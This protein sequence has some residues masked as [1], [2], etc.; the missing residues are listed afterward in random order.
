MAKVYANWSGT[1]PNLCS[2]KWTLI[3]DDVD[4]SEL[5]SHKDEMNTY[6]TY[7]NWYFGGESGWEEIWESYEDG[8]TFLDWQYENKDWLNKITTDKSVQRQ[9]YDAISMCDWR[10]G[11]CGGCI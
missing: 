6:G 5:I 2:G 8:L 7:E 10:H 11:S 9:I 1:Y 3:V 4:Y